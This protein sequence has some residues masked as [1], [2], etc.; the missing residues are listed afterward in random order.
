MMYMIMKG[1]ADAFILVAS[2][3][4]HQYLNILILW[5][6]KKKKFCFFYLEIILLRY[7]IW[8]IHIVAI[9]TYWHIA[10]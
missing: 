8:A 4:K 9:D 3:N 7:P 5:V 10:L 1:P 6:F 2:E